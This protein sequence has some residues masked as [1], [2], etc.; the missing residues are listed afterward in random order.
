MRTVHSQPRYAAILI[1]LVNPRVGIMQPCYNTWHTINLTHALALPVRLAGQLFH[2][3]ANHLRGFL[4]FPLPGLWAGRV[5][6]EATTSRQS[7]WAVMRRMQYRAAQ[8]VPAHHMPVLAAVG[9]ATT[10]PC[11]WQLYESALKS[12]LGSKTLP[13]LFILLQRR[14]TCLYCIYDDARGQWKY[15]FNHSDY[16]QAL[17]IQ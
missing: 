6:A 15:P 12:W 9:Y 10:Q 16:T 11:Y 1:L 4:G 17:G 14:T 3:A 13:F 5:R 7:N 8:C 2:H